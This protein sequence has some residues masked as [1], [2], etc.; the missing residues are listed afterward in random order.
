MLQ[1]IFQA[2]IVLLALQG[3][4]PA[5][6]LAQSAAG[7][8]LRP[9]PLEE[10]V[11]TS[12]RLNTPAGRVPMRTSVITRV[13]IGEGNGT[14]LGDALRPIPGLVV[15]E[16]GGGGGIQ[17]LSFRGGSSEQ[18]LI[19]VDGV[20]VAALETGVIDLR[21]LPLEEVESIEVVRGGMSSL[22]GSNAMGG[23]VNLKTVPMSSASVLRVRGSAGSFGTSGIAASSRVA[24]AGFVL[25][26][27]FQRDRSTGEFPV[28]S[29]T[30]GAA[31]SGV[32]EDNDFRSDHLFLRGDWA[33]ANADRTSLDVSATQCDRGSPGPLVGI[34]QQGDGR[35]SDAAYRATGSIERRIASALSLTCTASIQRAD[36][37]YADATGVFRGDNYYRNAVAAISPLLRYEPAAHWTAV[38]GWD[39]DVAVADG[40]ALPGRVQRSHGAWFAAAEI[41]TDTLNARRSVIALMPALRYETFSSMHPIWNPQLGLRAILDLGGC[42]A[43]AHASAGRSFR[44]PTM[45]EL[46]YSGAGGFGNPSLVP[47]VAV[48]ADA[49]VTI[50]SELLGH[51]ECDATFYSI[52]TDD[53]IFWQP[54]GSA[55]IWSP[56]NIARTLSRGFELEATW[57]SPGG[58]AE[59]HGAYA[60][61]DARNRSGTAS[62]NPLY[63]RQLPY[64]PLETAS[65]SALLR[66]PLSGTGALRMLAVRFADAFLGQRYTSDD[67]SSYLQAGHVLGGNLTLSFALLGGTAGIKYE[68]NNLTGG[69]VESIPG[70]PMPTR[71]HLISLTIE[72]QLGKS[73]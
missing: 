18:S 48:S 67:N 5:C 41:R 44:V 45:N 59:V 49:G 16:Y 24:M 36:E 8:S 13:A 7:D 50:A 64:I 28:N 12:T 52:R 54:A 10:I 39:L 62:D 73:L 53:R 34:A 35:Q 22:Y 32:R 55:L 69:N 72:Q 30:G 70:Y 40:N 29:P 11:I 71:N 47:E 23:M 26:G 21:M 14:T 31:L 46:H 63:D 15:R 65:M 27:G 6:A 37:H 56:V 57:T 1:R 60:F 68:L 4:L 51:T 58:T 33:S 17:T 25:S 19:L 2:S 66:L 3:M 20:P 38:T 9:F 42:T 61:V 43:T